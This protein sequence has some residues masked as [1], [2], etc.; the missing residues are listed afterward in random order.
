M[1]PEEL[2]DIIMTARLE[3]QVRAGGYQRAEQEERLKS[4]F[5]SG[6]NANELYGKRH[7]ILEAAEILDRHIKRV[8]DDL[9]AQIKDA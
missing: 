8:Y 4:D 9:Q 5:Q 2:R 6:Q 3:M 1:N 7:G